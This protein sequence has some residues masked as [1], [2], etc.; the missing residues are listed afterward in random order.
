MLYSL[1]I[2]L[3]S[4]FAADPTPSPSPADQLAGLAKEGTAIHDNFYAELKKAGHDMPRVVAAND[5]HR[6]DSSA[7]AERAG[8]VLK[9]H[10]AE[11]EALDVILAMNEIH[12]VPDAVPFARQESLRHWPIPS[13][14]YRFF[15]ASR[16]FP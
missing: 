10:P 4:F 7:W 9:A 15:G 11:P 2:L 1:P 6:A 16:A 8:V 12:Y 3:I 14:Q 13:P 5:K